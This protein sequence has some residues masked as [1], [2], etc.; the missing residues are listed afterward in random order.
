MSAEF[1]GTRYYVGWGSEPERAFVS[2]ML[3]TTKMTTRTPFARRTS[4]KPA[5]TSRSS[6]S[7]RE[8]SRPRSARSTRTGDPLGKEPFQEPRHIWWNFISTSEARIELVKHDWKEGRF[9]T[10]PG[11]EVEFIPLPES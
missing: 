2:A 8:R 1:R 7:R 4:P 9:P 3:R 11:D 10:M 5:Y 6:P